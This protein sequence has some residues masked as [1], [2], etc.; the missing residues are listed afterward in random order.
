MWKCAESIAAACVLVFA[1]LGL[2]ACSVLP[3]VASASSQE[4]EKGQEEFQRHE[5]KRERRCKK[6]E[7]ASHHDLSWISIAGYAREEFPLAQEGCY[8]RTEWSQHNGRGG[9]LLI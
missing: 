1:C 7:L 4:C 5:E 2:L 6:N 9:P 3:S 8:L